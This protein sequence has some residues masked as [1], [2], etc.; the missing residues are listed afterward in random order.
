MSVINPPLPGE[1]GDHCAATGLLP[2]PLEY[3]RRSDPAE[4]D[5]ERGIIGCRAQHHGLGRKPPARAQ[6]PL[7]LTARLQILETPSVAITC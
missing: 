1:I 3:Q 5:L 6:Q 7:Q 2:Q 4:R